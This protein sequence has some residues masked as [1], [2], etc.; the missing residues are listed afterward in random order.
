MYH[1]NMADGSNIIT[2]ILQRFYS[3]IL[4]RGCQEGAPAAP[5]PTHPPTHATWKDG[6]AVHF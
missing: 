2:S 4:Q 3:L 1:G 5:P 6:C